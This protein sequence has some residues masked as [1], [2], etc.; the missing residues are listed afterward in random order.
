MRIKQLVFTQ[1][2]QQRLYV[3]FEIRPI[4]IKASR[5]SLNLTSLSNKILILY[6]YYSILKKIASGHFFS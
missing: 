3:L 4:T 5:A 1:Q 6:I 2:F